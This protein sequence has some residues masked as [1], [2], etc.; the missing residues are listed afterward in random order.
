[1]LNIG[2]S[3]SEYF[4]LVGFYPQLYLLSGVLHELGHFVGALLIGAPVMGT[5]FT[6]LG[7]SVL[8][9]GFGDDLI[10][11][12]LLGGISQGVFLLPFLKKIQSYTFSS[13]LLFCLCYSRRNGI[14]I[15]YADFSYHFRNHCMSGN[16]RLCLVGTRSY[17]LDQ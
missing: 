12:R 6:L 14:T 3:K 4:V 9:N 11:T 7:F 10:I 8:I 1:M 5:E 15:T 2:P 17:G 13:F 16:H